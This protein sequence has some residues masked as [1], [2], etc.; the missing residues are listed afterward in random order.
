MPPGFRSVFK[1]V[2]N[3]TDIGRVP[4]SNR[5]DRASNC[6]YPSTNEEKKRLGLI[7]DSDSRLRRHSGAVSRTSDHVPGKK[8]KYEQIRSSR[9]SPAK[10]S[11]WDNTNASTTHKN[12][13]NEVLGGPSISAESL[14]MFVTP[15]KEACQVNNADEVLEKMLQFYETR[16]KRKVKEMFTTYP[17]VGLLYAALMFIKLE[18]P[19]NIYN[20]FYQTSSEHGMDD[21]PCDSSTA[22]K[23]IDVKCTKKDLLGSTSKSLWP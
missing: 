14:R 22:Y 18:M 7:N 5:L 16:K 15:W 6:P 13:N 21:T 3:N 23:S 4:L 10:E 9:S 20:T 11:K 8:R 1:P 17:F 19:D 12:P 2:G